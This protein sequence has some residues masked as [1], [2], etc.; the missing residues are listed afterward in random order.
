MVNLTID[1]N[2]VSVPEDY[3]IMEAAKSIGIKIPG[4]CHYEGI[5]KFGSCRICVV[6]VEGYARL[7]A[8]CLAKVVEG[9]VVR[10]ST[11]R[12]RHARRV[13]YELLLSD[14]DKQCLSC[15]RNQSC[16][17]QELGNTL[18]VFETRFD[19]EHSEY[20][21]D[22]SV[23]ITRDMSKCVLCRRCVTM[24]NEVQGVGT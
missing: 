8:S 6:E 20:N 7:Q 16:E 3:T 4:L 17:L 12:V 21:Y 24:C 9:M 13:L 1:G 10:T 15:S 5:H 18:G 19:G 14:H 22:T 23:A 2:S 11:Q